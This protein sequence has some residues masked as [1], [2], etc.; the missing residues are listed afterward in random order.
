MDALAIK[1]TC[2]K[3]DAQ[4]ERDECD[5]L[6]PNCENERAEKNMA[7]TEDG[8]IEHTKH[9]L[10]NQELAQL[11]RQNHAIELRLE[12][13]TGSNAMNGNEERRLSDARLMAKFGLSSV[14][15]SGFQSL[16]RKLQQIQECYENFAMN[17][18]RMIEIC[19]IQSL[20]GDHSIRYEV[21][22]QESKERFDAQGRL[23][24]DAM[25]AAVQNAKMEIAME[26]EKTIKVL[27]NEVVGD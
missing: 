2:E 9:D 6:C 26:S 27:L 20:D 12:Q 25:E 5:T 23:C 15:A 18:S 4:E 13:I 19:I 16:E 17:Q 10:L 22:T 11:T 24:M 8:E 14:L 7:A 3:T 21:M 1:K